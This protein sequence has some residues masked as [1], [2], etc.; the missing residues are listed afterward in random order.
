LELQKYRQI[1]VN[2]PHINFTKINPKN[3]KHL[4][5]NTRATDRL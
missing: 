1:L 3:R 2:I 4:I 5:T